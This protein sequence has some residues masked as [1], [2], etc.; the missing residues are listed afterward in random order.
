[1]LWG[2]VVPYGA[3][4][5]YE[6]DVAVFVAFV[7]LLVWVGAFNLLP[8]YP[9]VDSPAPAAGHISARC[10]IGVIWLSRLAWARFWRTRAVDRRW[11]CSSPASLLRRRRRLG[12]R[13]G[14]RVWLGANA[15][16]GGAC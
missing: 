16:M 15:L 8:A 2:G 14:H 1:M 3:G 13:D 11:P 4:L 6:S 7:C 5:G 10:T 12:N 9:P